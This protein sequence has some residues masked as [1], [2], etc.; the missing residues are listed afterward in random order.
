MLLAIAITTTAAAITI[1]NVQGNN[2]YTNGQ[3]ALANAE[4]GVEN[5]MLRLERD[6][7]YT[8]ETMSLSSGSVVITVTGSSP[9]TITATGAAGSFK[10]TVIATVTYSGSVIS[11]TSW[12]ETP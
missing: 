4:T 10:R 2:A 8:G 6:P 7:S 12:N 5:A 1:I 11:L 9:K 3:T